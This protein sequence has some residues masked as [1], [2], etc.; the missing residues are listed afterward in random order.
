M[1]DLEFIHGC[2]PRMGCSDWELSPHEPGVCQETRLA[3]VL[4]SVNIYSTLK[5]D[6]MEP[7]DVMSLFVLY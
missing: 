6:H 2:L 3:F 7:S 1:E 5:P 4:I